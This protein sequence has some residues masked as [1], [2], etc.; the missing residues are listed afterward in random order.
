M[1]L[2]KKRTHKQKIGRPYHTYQL[3]KEGHQLYPNHYETFPVELLD[4]LK[5][6]AGEEMV[7]ALLKKRIDRR[8]NNWNN[9]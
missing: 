5:E 4:D 7:Q 3:T 9:Y 8:K 1:D 6:I 2:F